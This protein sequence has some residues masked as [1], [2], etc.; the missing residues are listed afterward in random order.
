[1]STPARLLPPGF[2]RRLL[3]GLGLFSLGMVCLA[4]YGQ[5]HDVSWWHWLLLGAGVLSIM[6]GIV[7]LQRAKALLIRWVNALAVRPSPQ[8]KTPS[9]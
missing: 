8:P 5:L 3:P 2:L 1:M 6:G 9:S 7:F 4:L